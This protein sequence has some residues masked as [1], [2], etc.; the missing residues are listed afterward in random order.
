M[1]GE[2]L[3]VPP[4]DTCLFVC[5]DQYIVLSNMMHLLPDLYY[6]VPIPVRT[7]F[8]VTGPAAEPPQHISFSRWKRG[9]LVGI[10]SLSCSWW[11]HCQWPRSPLE[12]GFLSK[13]DDREVETVCYSNS[14]GHDYDKF[15]ISWPGGC[16]KRIATCLSLTS[17]HSTAT[18]DAARRLTEDQ[19]W[20]A[21]I[22]HFRVRYHSTQ[23]LVNNDELKAQLQYCQ[24][25]VFG[26]S[27]PEWCFHYLM[28]C[29]KLEPTQWVVLV[30]YLFVYLLGI[31]HRDK[32]IE[33]L[34]GG[35]SLYRYCTT[36]GVVWVREF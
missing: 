10:W 27:I 3:Y 36:W 7:N 14:N 17:P 18:N 8:R 9:I 24:Y 5:Q 32:V 28:T 34:V 1:R 12:L 20:H 4:S 25:T 26:H 23:D 22:K 29:F 33:A 6:P 2:E 11:S 19:R 16:V 21:R 13:Y 31:C 30:S 15:T 35:A